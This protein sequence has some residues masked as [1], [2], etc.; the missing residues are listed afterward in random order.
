MAALFASSVRAL[1][2][3]CF[4]VAAVL[5][6]ILMA[7][8]VFNVILRY[9]FSIGS[10]EL[11]EIQWHIYS[12]A[13]LLGLADVFRK[14]ANIRVDFLARV[15]SERARGLADIILLA[16]LALPFVGLFAYFAWGYFLTSWELGEVSPHS[17]GLPAR[18]LI[19]F[20]LF[21]AFL[22]LFLQIVETLASRLNEFRAGGQAQAGD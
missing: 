2:V 12:A 6:P 18:Y 13:F 9:G 21:F 16:L 14:D 7:V 1:S 3:G 19:K 4:A 11:E 10:I 17:S 15:F 8:I 5:Y 20:V 22:V